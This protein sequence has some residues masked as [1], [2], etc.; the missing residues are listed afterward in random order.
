LYATTTGPMSDHE[1]Q[2]PDSD[3]R[4]N[5]PIRQFERRS[6]V[7]GEHH[8]G[9]SVFVEEKLID[10][11]EPVEH[12]KQGDEIQQP[13]VGPLHSSVPGQ[14]EKAATN[15]EPGQ[16]RADLERENSKDKQDDSD[17]QVFTR[18]VPDDLLKA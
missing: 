17:G 4:K 7:A 3:R 10:R 2:A 12:G 13:A 9:H 18:K 6:A 16:P 8:A 15:C 14:Q 5:Q 11:V 1:N